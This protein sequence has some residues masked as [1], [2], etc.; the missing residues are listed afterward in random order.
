MPRNDEKQDLSNLSSSP[1]N[2]KNL[3]HPKITI[4]R[5]ETEV[6]KELLPVEKS[7]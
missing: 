3:N 4:E 5:I 1:E 6:N 2:R 7:Q